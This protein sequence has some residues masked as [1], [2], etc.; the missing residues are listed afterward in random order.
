M[1][2]AACLNLKIIR[3]HRKLLVAMGGP[4]HGGQVC[5]TSRKV[6]LQAALV[7]CSQAR[8]GWEAPGWGRWPRLQQSDGRAALSEVGGELN[9][10]LGLCV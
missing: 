2:S 3:Q 5:G 4:V 7:V 9:G 8:L 6:P 1:E 10:E